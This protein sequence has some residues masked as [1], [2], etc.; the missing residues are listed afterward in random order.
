MTMQLSLAAVRAQKRSSAPSPLMTVTQ[1][2][3]L[4]APSP[5]LPHLASLLTKATPMKVD[6]NRFLLPSP[7]RHLLVDVHLDGTA[8]IAAANVLRAPR[9]ARN[10]VPVAISD[11][12][13]NGWDGGAPKEHC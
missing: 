10:A 11:A 4:P 2:H 7:L 5:P 12:N 3:Q 6:E 8:S 13:P 1:A 9:D